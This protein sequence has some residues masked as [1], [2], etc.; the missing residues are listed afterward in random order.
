[1]GAYIHIIRIGAIAVTVVVAWVTAIVMMMQVIAI[2]VADGEIVMVINRI[3]PSDI[4]TQ[5][6]TVVRWAVVKV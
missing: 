1:M 4:V 5:I 6:R 2:S 3:T